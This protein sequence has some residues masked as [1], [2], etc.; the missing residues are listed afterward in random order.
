MLIILISTVVTALNINSYGELN[1]NQLQEI[2][3]L[4]NSK[5]EITIEKSINLGLGS[6]L[7]KLIHFAELMFLSEIGRRR[8]IN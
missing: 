4:A 6:T 8:L 5:N 1:N 3:K 2:G 7:F